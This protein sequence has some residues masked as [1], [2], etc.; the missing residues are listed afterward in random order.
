V[1]HLDSSVVVAVT[2]F[3]CRYWHQSYLKGR[4]PLVVN[5]NPFFVLEEDPT[6]SRNSQVIYCVQRKRLAVIQVSC[7]GGP[8]ADRARDV[9]DHILL[10]VSPSRDHGDAGR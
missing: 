4:D 6:P 2:G 7:V 3:P 8:G 1:A 10:E 9:V 5:V